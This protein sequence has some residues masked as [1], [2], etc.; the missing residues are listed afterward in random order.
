MEK[1][2]LRYAAR[3]F[4]IE[5]KIF[6]MSLVKTNLMMHITTSRK[7]GKMRCLTRTESQI[8]SLLLNLRLMNMRDKSLDLRLD[9][10]GI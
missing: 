3:H 7:N 6:I 10:I 4:Q 8:I 2:F 5:R 1:E 9:M